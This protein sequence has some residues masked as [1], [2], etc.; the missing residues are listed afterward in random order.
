MIPIPNNH[1]TLKDQMLAVITDVN[2][3]VAER[4]E[5][6]ELISIALLTR[7]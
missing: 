3:Q 6:V 4:E 7:A 1:S 2:A 5:L